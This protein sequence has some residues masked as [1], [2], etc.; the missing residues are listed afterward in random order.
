VLARIQLL[1]AHRIPAV[2]PLT[3]AARF[4]G[5]PFTLVGLVVLLSAAMSLAARRR[6]GTRETR[7]TRMREEGAE[8]T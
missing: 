3:L 4:V 6:W 8:A 1:L 7:R 2:S 5:G